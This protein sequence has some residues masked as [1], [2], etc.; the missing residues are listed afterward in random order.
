MNKEYF[1]EG[2]EFPVK[3]SFGDTIFV[4]EDI[5]A[6]SDV[7]LTRDKQKL[8]K[9]TEEFKHENDATRAQVK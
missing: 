8:K 1:V 3:L 6:C 4:F 5:D 9:S 2:L 7:V